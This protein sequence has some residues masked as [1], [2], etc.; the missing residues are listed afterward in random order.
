M[1]RAK[2]KHTKERKAYIGR[3]AHASWAKQRTAQNG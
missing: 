2:L 3:A 1:K